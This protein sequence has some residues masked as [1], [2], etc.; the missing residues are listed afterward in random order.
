MSSLW[1]VSTA[2]TIHIVTSIIPGCEIL[3][4]L[5]DILWALIHIQ[6]TREEED[7]T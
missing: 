2:I 5:P 7:R 3:K 1:M 4:I 6:N